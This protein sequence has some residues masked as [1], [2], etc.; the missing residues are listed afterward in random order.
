MFEKCGQ[1]SDPLRT[2]SDV[3]DGRTQAFEGLTSSIG[4]SDVRVW[5]SL[6]HSLPEVICNFILNN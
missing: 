4:V 6:Q 1:S 5:E 2:E 3:L